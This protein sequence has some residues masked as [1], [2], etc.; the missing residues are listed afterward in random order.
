[1]KTLLFILCIIIIGCVPRSLVI[2]YYRTIPPDSL[3]FPVGTAAFDSIGYFDNQKCSTCLSVLKEP[4]LFKDSSSKEIYRVTLLGSFPPMIIRLELDSGNAFLYAKQAKGN[5][6]LYV[7]SIDV[8]ET[9]RLTTE[10]WEEFVVRQHQIPFWEL[11]KPVKPS[12]LIRG[13][14][15]IMY[16]VEGK[17]Q[18]GYHVVCAT[19]FTY[20]DC[21]WETVMSLLEIHGLENHAFNQLK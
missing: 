3:Y 5:E 20:E 18:Q 2:S 13:G 7:D 10:P 8:N 12:F 19:N 11:P 21:L 4:I 9:R 1:M 14:G 15:L 16:I 6:P 17:N